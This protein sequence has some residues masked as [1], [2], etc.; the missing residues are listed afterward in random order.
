[1]PLDPCLT[2]E[3]F[4]RRFEVSPEAMARLDIFDEQLL[5]TQSHTNLIARSTIENRWERHYADSAQLMALIPDDARTIVDLGSGA[6]FPG[7]VLAAMGVERGLQVSMVESIGKKAAFL[8]RTAQ[9]MGLKNTHVVAGRIETQ[10]LPKPDVIT[11]RAL[12]NLNKLLGYVSPIAGPGTLCIFPKGQDV[13]FELTEA[14]KSWHITVERRQSIT[15][16]DATILLV[17]QR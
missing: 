10:S 16:P 3:D 8:A 15:S 6:G 7:L 5:D 17:Q 11:A 1:M 2:P 14:T 12:A 13:E 9:A 4:A